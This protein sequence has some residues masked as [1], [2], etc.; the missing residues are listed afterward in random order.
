MGSCRDTGG[1]LVTLISPT[2][3]SPWAG[4]EVGI[5]SLKLGSF[6]RRMTVASRMIVGPKN[7]CFCWKEELT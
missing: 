5:L 1:G 2:L 4:A 3:G 7:D 6:G